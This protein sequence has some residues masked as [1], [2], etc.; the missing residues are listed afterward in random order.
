M[1]RFIN[2]LNN[3]GLSLIATQFISRKARIQSN[4]IDSAPQA[5][6]RV[7]HQVQIEQQ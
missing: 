2:A 4:A 3:T 1:L 6:L 5:Q 7:L